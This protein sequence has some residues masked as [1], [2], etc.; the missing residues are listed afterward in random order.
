M[1]VILAYDIDITDNNGQRVLR[2][3][4]KICKRYLHHIQNSVFEGELTEVNLRRLQNDLS[5]WI[6]K[7]KDS[8]IV[9]WSRTEKWMHKE[10]WGLVKDDTGNII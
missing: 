2:N 8:V 5:R 10:I 4:F 3:V 1:Y 7:D 6:R 9:F